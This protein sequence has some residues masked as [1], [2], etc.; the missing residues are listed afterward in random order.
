MNDKQRELLFDAMAFSRELFYRIDD[1]TRPPEEEVMAVDGPAGDH[2]IRAGAYRVLLQTELN[3]AFGTLSPSDQE[4]DHNAV[5]VIVK[6]ASAGVSPLV[7]ALME[8]RR[9]S[10]PN[11]SFTSNEEYDELWLNAIA[12][13]IPQEE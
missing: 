4:K 12:L 11:R 3:G 1:L 6:P 9:R 7:D 5:G 8:L 13:A 10:L 2:L